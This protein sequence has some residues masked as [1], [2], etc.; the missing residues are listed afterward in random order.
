ML[1]AE[2]SMVLFS[3]LFVETFSLSL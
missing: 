3:N 2:I 1:P